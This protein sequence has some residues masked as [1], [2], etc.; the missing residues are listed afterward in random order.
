MGYLEGPNGELPFLR[1]T[2]KFNSH[3]FR[4]LKHVNWSNGGC[5]G[6]WDASGAQELAVA[7]KRHG[8][9]FIFL[10]QILQ[11]TFKFTKLQKPQTGHF[12]KLSYCHF[13]FVRRKDDEKK[14]VFFS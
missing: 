11:Q 10:S 12:F 5:A 3:D 13:P 9:V 6:I 1:P 8:E 2:L 7:Q 4:L 14:N